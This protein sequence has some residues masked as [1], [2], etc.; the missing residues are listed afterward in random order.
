MLWALAQYRKARAESPNRFAYCVPVLK[1]GKIFIDETL[2]RAA[3]LIGLVG[4]IA[5]LPVIASKT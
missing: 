4:K 2:H 1:E 3:S 5:T